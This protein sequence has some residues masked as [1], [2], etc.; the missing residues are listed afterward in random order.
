MEIW[1]RF[2]LLIMAISLI[3]SMFIAFIYYFFAYLISKSF[4]YRETQQNE[5]DLQKKD[6]FVFDHEICGYW[7]ESSRS[8]FNEKTKSSCRSCKYFEPYASKYGNEKIL[9]FGKC[10]N[11]STQESKKSNV[12]LAAGLVKRKTWVF[13]LVRFSIIYLLVLMSVSSFH[14]AYFKSPAEVY[15]KETNP[16]W[17]EDVIWQPEENLSRIV[18]DEK[19]TFPLSNRLSNISSSVDEYISPQLTASLSTTVSASSN[20]FDSISL[21][22][23]VVVID[24]GHGNTNN[25]GGVGPGGLTENIVVLDIAKFLKELLEKDLATVYL[26]RNSDTTDM[27]NKARGEYANSVKADIFVRIH[28]DPD[29]SN[30]GT[31]RKGFI[32]SWYKENSQD[33]AYIFEKYLKQ[34]GRTSLGVMK[35]Y[36]EGLEAANVPAVTVDIA[37][38]TNS[39]EEAL[40]KNKSFLKASARAAHKAIKEFLINFS[41]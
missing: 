34:E 32:V 33:A 41:N 26:T 18:S 8:S 15:F 21:K 16:G 11:E 14:F 10:L 37:K 29:T 24:P 23:K 4:R 3:A 25:P 12:G 30:S 35:V 2:F 36:S 1:I 17:S 5:D 22:G 6:N 40:L 28:A 9:P 31:K 38:I 13:Y 39:D 19:S 20:K 27:D 7:S